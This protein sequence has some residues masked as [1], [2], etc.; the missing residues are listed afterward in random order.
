M[1]KPL[2]LALL[3]AGCPRQ[4]SQNSAQCDGG[5]AT[6]VTVSVGNSNSIMFSPSNLTIRQGDTVHWVW[7]SSGHSLVS[8]QGCNVDNLF[9]SQNNSD[10][11]GASAQNQGD[12]YDHT[13][14]ATGTFPYHCAQHCAFGMLGSVTVLPA[15][16]AVPDGG[17]PDAGVPDAGTVDAGTTDAGS[18]DAGTPPDGGADAG[19]QTITVEVGQGGLMFVPSSVTV[20]VGDTVHWVWASSGHSVVSG[21]TTGC[22]SD[23]VFGTAGTQSTGATYDFTFTTAGSFQYHCGPHCQFGMTGTVVVQ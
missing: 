21:A 9:C 16:S 10:C 8:G 15:C 14:N 5:A 13:F 17:T 2:V 23:G 4:T 20:N 7:G 12:T 1:R 18:T 22:M 3:L 6:T 19:P 11:S